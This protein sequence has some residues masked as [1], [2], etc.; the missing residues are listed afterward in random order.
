[1]E[2]AVITDC[3]PKIF[4]VQLFPVDAIDTEHTTSHLRPMNTPDRTHD[5]EN[6]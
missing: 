1:M 4:Y 5:F 2:M 6:C 3:E